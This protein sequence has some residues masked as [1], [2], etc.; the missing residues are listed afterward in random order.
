MERAFSPFTVTGHTASPLT[1]EADF[2]EAIARAPDALR[3][4]VGVGFRH[5][6]SA[7]D[8][9]IAHAV[10][11]CADCHAR[12]PALGLD[13]SSIYVD[14]GVAGAT[15]ANAG[16]GAAAACRIDDAA[17][18]IDAA[19]MSDSGA[20]AGAVLA[21]GSPDISAIDVHL[22]I[23]VAAAADAGGVQAACR[24][25][26][27]A[28]DVDIDAVDAAG[29]AP[30]PADSGPAGAALRHEDGAIFEIRQ[31]EIGV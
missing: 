6:R 7:G 10:A 23:A 15:A 5:D 18:Y 11:T 13:K 29:I 21:A 17:P 31:R 14:I 1:R 2:S 24:G 22:G 28:V 12:S 30:S 20:D 16:T 4:S 26:I 3:C 27:A 9:D 19:C 25:D 8:V